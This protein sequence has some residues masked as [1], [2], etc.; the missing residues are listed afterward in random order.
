MNIESRL[1]RLPSVDSRDASFHM[2]AILP[3]KIPAISSRY[4]NDNPVFLDQGNTPTCVGHGWT[5]WFN[6]GPVK[7]K[8]SID[9]F[10]IYNEAQKVDE[11][12]GEDYEGTSVRAG[13]KAMAARGWIKEYRWAWDRATTV[14]AVL[15]TG[16]VVVGTNFYHDMAFPDQKGLIKIGGPVIGGH[17]YVLNGVNTKAKLFRIKNSWGRGWGLNGRA[18]ISFDDMERLIKEDGEICLAVENK[19]A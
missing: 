2:R 16:P 11:W 17:C 14:D 8:A 18:W 5:H 9:P 1:G 12:P 13:A 4:W 19:T 7:H 3:K 15:T 6:D 10:Q